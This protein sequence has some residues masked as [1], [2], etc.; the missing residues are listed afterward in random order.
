[1]NKPYRSIAVVVVLTLLTALSSFASAEE[2]LR[3]GLDCP[4]LFTKRGNYQGIHIIS[5]FPC[6]FNISFVFLK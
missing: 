6:V 5:G 4:I 1:M 3:K 2:P